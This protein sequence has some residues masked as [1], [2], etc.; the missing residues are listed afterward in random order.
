[1]AFE[2]FE[3]V[4]VTEELLWHVWEGED[5]RSKGGHR[6]GLGRLFKTEFPQRWSFEYLSA[7]VHQT[8]S[9]PQ[10]VNRQGR[11]TVCDREIDGVIVRVVLAELP[12][13]LRIHAVYPVCGVGVFRN[14]RTGRVPLPLDL[15]FW[16]Q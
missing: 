13:H 8:L 6:F 11:Y 1:M 4:S 12:S 7:A 2:S 9:H 3:H 5:D 10:F 15:Y 14:D 16:E